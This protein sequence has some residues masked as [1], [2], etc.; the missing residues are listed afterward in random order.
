MKSGV[1]GLDELIEGGFPEA[2][3]ILVSGPAG[4]GKSILCMEYLY[5]GAK[6]YGEPGVYITME[7]GPHNIWW[8]TQRF[9]WD[10]V[11]LEREGKL[12]IYKFEPTQEILDSPEA[13]VERIIEKARSTNAK[14]LVVDSVT[15]FAFWLKDIRQIRFAIYTLIEELRKLDCTTLLTC[16]TPAGKHAVSR[17]GVEEFLTDG[18]LQMFFSPPNRAMFVRKMR[19]TNHSKK[20]HPLTIN[21]NGLSVESKEEILWEGLK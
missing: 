9:K 7:E 18:V 17:F 19:G 13:Q 16:E 20:I 12:K 2:S 5:N 11:S 21:D 4:T 10:L 1:P 3:S 8:N 15:A 14:R 6:E